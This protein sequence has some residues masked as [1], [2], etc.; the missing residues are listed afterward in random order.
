MNTKTIECDLFI[1]V[2][3][4]HLPTCENKIE[5]SNDFKTAIKQ[6]NDA[7]WVKCGSGTKQVG[8]GFGRWGYFCPKHAN[9]NQFYQGVKS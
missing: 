2:G 9:C 1:F 7:G 5:V 3:Y 4:P 6:M 8:Y